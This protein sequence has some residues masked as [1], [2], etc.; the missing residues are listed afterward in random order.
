MWVWV[1]S[2]R[3]E[4]RRFILCGREGRGEVGGIFRFCF[5]WF[6]IFMGKLF[7]RVL[8]G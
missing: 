2:C 3:Y 1:G 7:W 4:D 5:E 6:W 8:V